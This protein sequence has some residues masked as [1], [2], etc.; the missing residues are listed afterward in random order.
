RMSGDALEQSQQ[1]VGEGHQVG[2]NDVVELLAELERLAGPNL[3][4]KFGMTR[5]RELDH[6]GTDVDAD[7]GGRLQRGKQIAGPR[8]D[9]EHARPF[10]NLEAV[11]LRDEAVV[12]SIA[13]APARLVLREP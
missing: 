3:E 7:S 4:A 10:R 13:S 2:E 12:R 1:V 6:P 9:L 11:D 5:A 8:A